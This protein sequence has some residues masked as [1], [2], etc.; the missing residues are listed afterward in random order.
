MCNPDYR[1]RIPIQTVLGHP[2]WWNRYVRKAYSKQYFLFF[3]S[4]KRLN[5]VRV[6]LG[7]V[8]FPDGNLLLED[9]A[10]IFQAL[11]GRSLFGHRNFAF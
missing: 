2:F 3:V 8:A 9:I 7:V 4:S 6:L 11:I 1:K 5:F 10:Q